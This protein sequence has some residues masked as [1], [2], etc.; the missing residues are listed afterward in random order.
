MKDEGSCSVSVR[1]AAVH[2]H[3]ILFRVSRI[4]ETTPTDKVDQAAAVIGVPRPR[5]TLVSVHF[6]RPIT[7]CDNACGSARNQG[8]RV[9][10]GLVETPVAH[11]RS[12]VVQREVYR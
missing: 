6:K 7:T 1:G 2:R 3:G 8:D 10:Q 12:L 11:V 5:A 4:A 9:E